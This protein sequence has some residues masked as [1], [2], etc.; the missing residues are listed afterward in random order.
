[1]VQCPRALAA[2][3]GR[4]AHRKL[5]AGEAGDPAALDANYIRRSDAELLTF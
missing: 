2:A 1:V 4:I 5:E 3:I